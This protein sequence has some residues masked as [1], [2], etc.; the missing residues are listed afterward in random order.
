MP[1][2]ILIIVAAFHSDTQ[3]CEWLQV[4]T[5]E[6]DLQFG[7]IINGRPHVSAS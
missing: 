7:D 5:V 6:P 4:I 2:K 3:S 1:P